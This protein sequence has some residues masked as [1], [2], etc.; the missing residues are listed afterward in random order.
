[1]IA[2]LKICIWWIRHASNRPPPRII[3]KYNYIMT[4]YLF[5]A[6]VIIRLLF[7]P[8]TEYSEQWPGNNLRLLCIKTKCLKDLITNFN[9]IWLLGP[10]IL[11][12]FEMFNVI[13]TRHLNVHCHI[14]MND[15]LKFLLKGNLSLSKSLVGETRMI[16]HVKKE[17]LPTISAGRT[18]S[19]DIRSSIS[20]SLFWHTSDVA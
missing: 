13:F 20:L 3:I 5:P 18:L 1:M 14:T 16:S 4:I 15:D 8:I 6:F 2:G 17:I 11:K 7:I 10:T 9:I 19:F 12:P